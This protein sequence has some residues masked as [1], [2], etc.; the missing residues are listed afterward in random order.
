M[1]YVGQS[2]FMLF[3]AELPLAYVLLIKKKYKKSDTDGRMK[4]LQ[5]PERSPAG[6]C[7]CLNTDRIDVPS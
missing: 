6:V 7:Q 4:Y 1:Q 5:I 2:S 3:S